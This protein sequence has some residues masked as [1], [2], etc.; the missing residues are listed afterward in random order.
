MRNFLLSYLIPFSLLLSAC[1]SST[2]KELSTIEPR[3]R[4][5]PD[6]LLDVLANMDIS[7]LG[8]RGLAYY[9]LLTTAELDINHCHLDDSLVSIAHKYYTRHGTTHQRM[10]NTYYYGRAQQ[11]NKNYPEAILSLYQAAEMAREEGNLII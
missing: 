2:I 4:E 10:L 7:R 9:A 6:S 11:Q 5:K 1:T 8:N 3:L